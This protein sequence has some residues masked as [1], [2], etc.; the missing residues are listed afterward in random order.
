M[1]SPTVAPVTT[2]G[3]L[4]ST[5]TIESGE[6][7]RVFGLSVW[8]GTGAPQRVQLQRADTSATFID[9]AVPA[10]R[11]EVFNIKFLAPWG[12]QVASLGDA[13]ASVTVYHSHGGS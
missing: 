11:T 5:V 10:N 8:N 7:I 9:L 6:T 12:L 3:L 2:Y 13:N 4:S 1:G